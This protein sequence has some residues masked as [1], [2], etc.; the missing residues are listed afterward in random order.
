MVFA[1]VGR[2]EGSRCNVL[3]TAVIWLAKRSVKYCLHT[4]D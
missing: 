1:E 3:E 4:V 2:P